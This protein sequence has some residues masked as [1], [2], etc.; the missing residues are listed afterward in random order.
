[1]TQEDQM[2]ESLTL[3]IWLQTIE[4]HC[5]EVLLESKVDLNREV[6]STKTDKQVKE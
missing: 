6:N 3:D 2:G 5:D 1:M 4:W